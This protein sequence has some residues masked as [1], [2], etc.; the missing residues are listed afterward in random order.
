M[1]MT[2]RHRLE[3]SPSS[4]EDGWAGGTEPA[5][6]PGAP[7]ADATSRFAVRSAPGPDRPGR[8][9]S[10]PAQEQPGSPM[11][12]AAAAA[13]GI[14]ST[15]PNWGSDGV[16]GSTEV[17]GPAA[18]RP[19]NGAAAGGTYLGLPRRVRQASLTPQLR[20][21][22]GAEPATSLLHPGEAA[23]SSPRSPEQAS[24]RLSALQ[25][26]WL[27]GRVDDLDD[28]S[29]LDL[30]GRPEGAS[31]GHVEPNHREVES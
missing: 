11:A 25:D 22:L 21:P 5:A 18:G 2:G 13:W 30:G 29:E 19:A 6:G 26:G 9:A 24:S 3:P 28:P 15:E 27:R 31:G 16:T 23:E 20:G 12:A 7:L 8:W 1:G 4:P 14:G 10:S 17:T